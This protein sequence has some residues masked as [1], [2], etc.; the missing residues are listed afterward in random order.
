V[1]TKKQ[2]QQ[3]QRPS[4]RDV[5]FKHFLDGEICHRCGA[6]VDTYA[7]ACTASLDDA[8]P[9]FIAIEEALLA[10]RKETRT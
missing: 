2:Q 5:A 3:E 6:T 4:I 10:E 9:G 7:D 8:C 1:K